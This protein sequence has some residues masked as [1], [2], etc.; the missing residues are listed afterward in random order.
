VTAMEMSSLLLFI[1]SATVFPGL[2]F[3]VILSLSTQ[4][5]VR[6]I[7]ARYQRRMGPTYVGP[8]GILQPFVDLWKLLRS[9]EVA[10]S[11]YSMPGIAEITLLVGI[12]CI[13]G[14]TLL[15]PISPFN[16]RSP[17]DFLIFFYMSCVMPVL[18][19]I[20]AS[21]SMPGP[22]TSLGVSRML[23]LL[24][25]CEPVYFT[26]LFI[27]GF[28]ATYGSELVLSVSASSSNIA[29]F[30]MNP[31]TAIILTLSLIALIVA[32]QSK[33]MYPPFNIP[34]AEQ[35][36]IAGFETEFSGPLLALATLLHDMDLTISLLAVVYIVLGG[37][38][39]FPQFSI[40]GVVMVILKYILVLLIAVTIK[41]IFGRYRLEQALL[42]LLKYGGVPVV[43]STLLTIAWVFLAS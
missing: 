32:I 26:G 37:P 15:L 40:G 41:N 10:R 7:S 22:Y 25:I 8:L 28:I 17:L 11:K 2:L 23:S 20:F 30:W 4:Y 21:L 13:A 12:S 18:M 9:K 27:P 38:A 39:P 29:R 31:V 34:E 14:S 3:M 35:E 36:L 5:L 19:M 43:I 1:V 6:K 24:T 42:Q 33:A 16:V